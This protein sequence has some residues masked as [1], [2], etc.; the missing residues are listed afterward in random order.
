MKKAKREVAVMILLTLT[1]QLYSMERSDETR[2]R[3]QAQ[4]YVEETKSRRKRVLWIGGNDGRDDPASD[5]LERYHRILHEDPSES[6]DAQRRRHAA[7]HD[8]DVTIAGNQITADV[9][10]DWYQPAFWDA[11]RRDAEKYG[12]YDAIAVD[13]GSEYWMRAQ[14]FAQG[15]EEKNNASQWGDREVWE[16]N[17]DATGAIPQMIEA[18]D[19]TLRENGVFAVRIA[20]GFTPDN[21][22]RW[23]VTEEILK[24]KNFELKDVQRCAVPPGQNDPDMAFNAFQ[25]GSSKSFFG[26]LTLVGWFAR[27]DVEHVSTDVQPAANIMPTLGSFIR[28]YYGTTSAH[29]PGFPLPDDGILQYIHCFF[30]EKP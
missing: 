4:M 6:A 7:E 8:Y 23:E 10:G 1:T 5:E 11:V 25:T 2:L 19:Q 12:K 9:R 16:L 24:G 28:Q 15:D 17:A 26:S 14:A 3:N 29:V 13:Y 20:G 22:T 27:Q 21:F 18:V 30:E